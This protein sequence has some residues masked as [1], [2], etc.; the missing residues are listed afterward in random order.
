MENL[1]ITGFEWDGIT[2]IIKIVN[3]DTGVMSVY[4]ITAGSLANERKATLLSQRNYSN[5]IV[6]EE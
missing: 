1:I 2:V 4:E 5:T 6:Q 3:N